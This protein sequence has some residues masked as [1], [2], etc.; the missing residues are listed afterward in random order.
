MKTR[1]RIDPFYIKE[2]KHNILFIIILSILSLLYLVFL[3]REIASF[4]TRNNKLSSIKE[5]LSFFRNKQTTLIR[6]N[7]SELDRALKLFS[8]LIPTNEDYYTIISTLRRLSEL[9]GLSIEKYEISFDEKPTPITKITIQTSG[10]SEKLFNFF[11]SYLIKGGRLVTLDAIEYIPNFT[12]KS[13][14]IN[15]HHLPPLQK[16]TSYTIQ[17]IK[18]ALELADKISQIVNYTQNDFDAQS[19][20]P[21]NVIPVIGEKQNPFSEE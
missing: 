2:L 10:D 20:E 15:F 1:F 5:E 8:T 16:T 9:S 7:E 21:T 12:E 11:N 17:S 13:I 6:F 14:T 3:P 4:I 18:K 19:Q